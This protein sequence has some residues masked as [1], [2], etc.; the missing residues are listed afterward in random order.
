MCLIPSAAPGKLIP[1]PKKMI[2]TMYGKVAVK[3]TACNKK[4]REKYE[5]ENYYPIVVPSG[6]D[7]LSRQGLGG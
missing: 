7:N 5:K 1:R 3:Y 6:M 2:N 4:R